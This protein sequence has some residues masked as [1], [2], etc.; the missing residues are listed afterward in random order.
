MSGNTF[1]MVGRLNMQIFDSGK[2]TLFLYS[3]F[4]TTLFIVIKFY[5]LFPLGSLK[6]SVQNAFVC[7]HDRVRSFHMTNF[8]WVVTGLQESRQISL[9]TYSYAA[10]LELEPSTFCFQSVPP[11]YLNAN[12]TKSFVHCF[13]I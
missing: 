3:A 13:E 10:E 12:L 8:N 5:N 2:R 6:C 1:Y 4:N 9:D 7:S 11:F